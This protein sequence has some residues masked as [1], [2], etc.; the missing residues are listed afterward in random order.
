MPV[1]EETGLDVVAERLAYVREMVAG[2]NHGMEFYVVCTVQGG[3]LALGTDPEHK[4]GNMIL[5]DVRQVAIADFASMEHWY[6]TE[7]HTII[8]RDFKSGFSET[9][10]LGTA[11]F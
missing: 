2:T 10:F 3:V 9:R 6:P 1:K 7:L 8:E 4:D 11:R 5:K